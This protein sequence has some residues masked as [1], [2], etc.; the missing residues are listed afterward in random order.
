MK[1][2]VFV[3]ATFHRWGDELHAFGS[4]QEAEACVMEYAEEFWDEERLGPFPDDYDRLYAAWNENGLWGSV[5]SRWELKRFEIELPRTPADG[6]STTA[7][8]MGRD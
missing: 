4:R 2:T 5:E 3:V 6:A 1:T 7:G 8:T